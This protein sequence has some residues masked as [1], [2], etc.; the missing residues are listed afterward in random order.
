[1]PLPFVVDTKRTYKI[2]EP[3]RRYHK[4]WIAHPKSGLNQRQCI[5]QICFAPNGEH[6][7]IA[8]IFRGKGKKIVEDERQAWHDVIRIKL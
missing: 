4:I 5:H 8:V 6:P 2:V 3:G 7:R 1:M